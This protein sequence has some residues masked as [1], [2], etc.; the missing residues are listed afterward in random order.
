MK[1]LLA[2]AMLITGTLMM[3]SCGDDDGATVEGAIT[4]TG[5]PTNAQITAGSSLSVTTDVVIAAEDGISAFTVSIE[6]GTALDLLAGATDFVAGD[7]SYTYTGG[8]TLDVSALAAA[9]YEVVFTLTDVGGDT[10]MFTHILTVNSVPVVSVTGLLEGTVNWTADNIYQL[11]GKVVVED[12][13]TLNIA[14]GTIIKGAEGEGSLASALVVARGGTLNISGTAVAPVIFTSV[15]DNIQPGEVA[16]TSL[17]IDDTGEWGG[18]IILGNGEISN[19]DGDTF[20]QIE[21]I[22]ADDTFGA[23]GYGDAG[24]DFQT[25]SQTAN[26]GT[27]RYFSIRHG[28]ALI[29]QG[30]EINGLTMG[31]VGSGTT[32]EYVEVVANFD[33]GIEPFGGAANITNALV[34]GQGDDAYDCDESYD[35]TIS[36]FIYIAGPESDHG[37]EIDGP[38]GTTHNDGVAKFR[39][40]SLKGSATGDGVEYGDFR[41]FAQVDIDGVYAFGFQSGKD[42]EIDNS[43]GATDARWIGASPVSSLTNMTINSTDALTDLFNNTVDAGTAWATPSDFASIVT[44]APSTGLADA[45]QFAGWT[46]ADSQGQLSDF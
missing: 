44:S 23:Y 34:W 22:P 25:A 7:A 6:G 41:V 37:F 4:I 9:V 1:R 24:S 20:G 33:D 46:Y 32:I 19:G 38:K 18:L 5:I 21:G 14:A 13:V 3:V 35:G 2:I 16:G 15:N 17:D 28:G 31:G 12:G 26:S 40:G 8:F 45:T 30:N 10:E 43:D 11:N 36:N 27:M 39:N 42:Y 29:G